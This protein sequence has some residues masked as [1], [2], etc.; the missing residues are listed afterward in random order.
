MGSVKNN[1]TH[2]GTWGI[3]IFLNVSCEHEKVSGA[4]SKVSCEHE[5][6]GLSPT[7]I[8]GSVCVCV[9]VGVGVCE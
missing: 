5:K 7:H 9:W 3:F 1:G 4:H 8:T 2:K 6:V